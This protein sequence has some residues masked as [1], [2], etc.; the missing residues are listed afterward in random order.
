MQKMQGRLGENKTRKFL[1]TL[2]EMK[3]NK[4]FKEF[5]LFHEKSL[6]T[7]LERLDK[8]IG[9][10]NYFSKKLMAHI[11]NTNQYRKLNAE[12]FEQMKHQTRYEKSMKQIK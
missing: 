9:R 10:Y 2:K 8:D 4:H 5:F 1:Q 11:V 3:D 7:G 12:V 6:K